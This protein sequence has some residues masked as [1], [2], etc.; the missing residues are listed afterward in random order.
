VETTLDADMVSAACPHCRILVVE[1]SSATSAN[2]AAAE[3]TAARL[4]ANAISDSYGTSEG[5]A[6]MT[7]A[8]AYDHPGHVIVVASGDAGFTTASFPA[9]LDTVTAVGGTELA[10]AKNKRGWTERVWNVGVAASGSGCSAY[11]PKPP[12]QHDPH[13][14]MR[15]T[16]DVSAVA[17]NV[18][19]YEAKF[20]GWL[21][22]GGTSAAAPLIAGVYALAGNAATVT[23]GY[24]Y[25]H[26]RS[27]FNITTGNNDVRGGEQCGHDYL[28]TARKGYN[29]P[30]GLGT[31]DGTAA[32]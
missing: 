30:T 8:G 20:G 12:W 10:R 17:W 32:F 11:E 21:T 6:V 1:A 22:V 27:L 29:A 7:L 23:L 25:S 26:A 18:A 2:L 19:I 15:T 9:N 16:A 4:G 24:E 3:D 31:P 5:G 13:C 14:P 28:C